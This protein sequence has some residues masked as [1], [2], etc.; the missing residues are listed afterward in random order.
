M[1]GKITMCINIAEI[2]KVIKKMNDE[3]YQTYHGNGFFTE[4]TCTFNDPAT[5]EEI[6]EFEKDYNIVIP[7]D[8]KE[9]LLTTNGMNLLEDINIYGLGDILMILETGIYKEGVYAIAYYNG[10]NI[11][12]NSADVSEG[13]YLY[14][15]DHDSVDEFIFLNTNFETMLDRLISINGRIYWDWFDGYKFHNFG[16]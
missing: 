4:F 1:G 8:F 2:M 6:D 14:T 15:G 12:I 11:V 3:K 10:D 5:I 16:R 7:P 13:K 9:F